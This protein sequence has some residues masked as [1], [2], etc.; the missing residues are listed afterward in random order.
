MLLG[1]DLSWY[2][3]TPRLH[4]LFSGLLPRTLSVSGK[5]LTAHVLLHYPIT[6]VTCLLGRMG[7]VSRS[8]HGLIRTEKAVMEIAKVPV[9]EERSQTLPPSVCSRVLAS[10][11]LQMSVKS[12]FQ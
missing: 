6:R 4:G 12:T 5:G 7:W 8:C 11:A 3:Q 9:K 10:Q 2:S 1:D